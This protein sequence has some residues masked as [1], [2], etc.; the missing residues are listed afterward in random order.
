[1]A[2]LPELRKRKRPSPSSELSQRRLLARLR[3]AE[4][5]Q[6]FGVSQR[7]PIVTPMR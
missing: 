1:M 7:H 3:A 2:C 4:V 5:S 6:P